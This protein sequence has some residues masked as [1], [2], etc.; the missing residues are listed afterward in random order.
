MPK[1]RKHTDKPA[2]GS[3]RLIVRQRQIKVPSPCM[4]SWYSDLQSALVL[5]QTIEFAMRAGNP[6]VLEYSSSLDG[7]HALIERAAEGIDEILEPET[8]GAP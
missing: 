6:G 2:T 1:A 7:A 4:E 8:Q 5:I 3:A